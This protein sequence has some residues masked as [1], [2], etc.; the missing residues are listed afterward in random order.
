MTLILLGLSL[1]YFLHFM[2]ATKPRFRSK[3]I[4]RLGPNIY[5]GGFALGLVGAIALMSMGWRSADLGSVY[6]PPEWSALPGLAL[7]VVGV[8]LFGFGFDKRMQTNLK[9]FIRHLQLTGMILW[10]SGHLI[11]NGDNRSVLLFGGLGLWALIMRALVNR[12]D[13]PWLKPEKVPFGRE[14][15]PAVI[16]LGFVAGFVFGHPYLS[17]IA[18]VNF[19]ALAASAL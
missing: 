11:L 2:P 6:I 8:I 17:G 14:F 10:A 16:A 7:V 3:A 13:G 19:Q 5:A 18:L 4:K 9:R 12:R 1:W 15:V